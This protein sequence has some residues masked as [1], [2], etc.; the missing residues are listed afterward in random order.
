[1]NLEKIIPVSAVVL[2]LGLVASGC[3]SGGTPAATA[4]GATPAAAGAPAGGAGRAVLPVPKNPIVNAA[5]APGLTITRALVENNV[6]DTGK[7]ADDHL[8]I[9]LKNTT[10]KPLGPIEVYYTITDPAKKLSDGYYATLDGLTIKPGATEVVNFDNSGQP[11]HYPVNRYSL[12]YTDKN[13]LV[14]DLTA[15]A[16]GVKQA[17]FSVKKDAGGAEA[18]VE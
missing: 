3:G 17:T 15:S 10:A 5:T 14:V 9:G 18:G 12:Y 7:K 16:A 11:G 2:S 6:T 8:E 1:M 4:P 13:A